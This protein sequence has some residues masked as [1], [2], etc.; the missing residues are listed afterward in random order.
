MRYL[1]SRKAAEALGVHPNTLRRWADAGKIEHIKTE[2]GQRRYDVD[3]YVGH[4]SQPVG[5]CYCRVS[6]YKQ[7][8]DL[9]RQVAFMQEQ[10]PR[11]EIVRDIGSG[12]NFKRKGLRSLL[13]RLLQGDKLRVMVAHKDRL[14]RFGFECIQ[15]LVEQNGGEIVVLDQS[16]LSPEREL[17]ED[18]LAILNV[19]SCRMHGRRNYKGKKGQA[20]SDDGI[21]KDLQAMVRCIEVCVQQ[22]IGIPPDAWDQGE[23]D[24]DR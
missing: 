8:D 23:L 18:L 12:L 5:I 22:N 20:I 10:H 1:P 15:F 4:R 21:E 3:S 9:E 17:T 13:E 2:S 6:S 19:F 7:K 11:Y 14:A 16:H 24:G